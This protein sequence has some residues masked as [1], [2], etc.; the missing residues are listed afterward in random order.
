MKYFSRISVAGEQGWNIC[1]W[2]RR[3]QL[4]LGSLLSCHPGCSSTTFRHRALSTACSMLCARETVSVGP[5]WIWSRWSDYIFSGESGKESSRLPTPS[6]YF[7]RGVFQFRLIRYISL[8]N[9]LIK[10]V[11]FTKFPFSLGLFK[12]V[13]MGIALNYYTLVLTLPTLIYDLECMLTIF[14]SDDRRWG[15]LI[16]GGVMPV[17]GDDFRFLNIYYL[18]LIS[19]TNKQNCRS[20]NGECHSV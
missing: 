8:K 2:S 7:Q 17:I 3:L 16:L 18:S 5:Q 1:H 6:Y 20:V 12:A 14:G 15:L 19:Q 4:L 10:G 11:A 9:S 13:F